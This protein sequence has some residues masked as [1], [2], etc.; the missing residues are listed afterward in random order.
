WLQVGVLPASFHAAVGTSRPAEARL[1]TSMTRLTIFG[2]TGFLGKRVIK[3]ALAQNLSVRSASRHREQT[4]PANVEQVTADIG[5]DQSVAMAVAH[6]STV[7]NAASLYVEKANLSFD[8]VHVEGAARVARLARQ[9]G[10]Q[11]LV[12]VSGMGANPHS[13]SAY[14][15]A[16]GEG[17]L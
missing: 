1:Q 15:R 12:H 3:S 7:V 13:E 6:A 17:E 14:I 16:R 5:N 11:R 8:S 2:G 10:V 4:E 9:A